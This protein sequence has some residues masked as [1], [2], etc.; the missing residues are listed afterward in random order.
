[1][2]RISVDG[3]VKRRPP[4]SDEPPALRLMRDYF[5]ICL[6]AT[7]VFGSLLFGMIW[8]AARGAFTADMAPRE[9]SQHPGPDSS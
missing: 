8:G 2:K 3:P 4:T 9:F 5:G 7:L 1:M 6:G